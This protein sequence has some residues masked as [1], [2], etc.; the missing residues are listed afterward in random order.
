[1]ISDEQIKKFRTLYKN[2]FGEEISQAEAYR[3]GVKLVRLMELVYKPITK[4]EYANSLKRRKEITDGSI[5]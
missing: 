3:Q 5:C 4:Q 1:M 2:H